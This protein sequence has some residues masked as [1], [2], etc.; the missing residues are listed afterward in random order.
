MWTRRDSSESFTARPASGLAGMGL[1]VAMSLPLLAMS[2][3]AAADPFLVHDNTA[4]R[5]NSTIR[6]CFG[7]LLEPE[8]RSC[9]YRHDGPRYGYYGP[10]GRYDATVDCDRAHPGYVEEVVR[11]IR[12]GG[13]LY[14]HAHERSCQ[15]SLTLSRSI[16]IVGQ[17]YGPDQIPAIVAPDGQP[18][19]TVAPT[20]THVVLK[21]VYMSSPRGEQSSCVTAAD[22]EV[23]IQGS[24][25][26]YQGE[27]PAVLIAGGRL[28][29]I[30]ASHVIAKT[31]GAAIDVSKAQLLA[32]DSEIATT[33][34]GI[35]AT[36]TG[37]SQI[38]GVSIQQLSD[39]HG[40]DRGENG[41]GVDI[42]LD[43]VDTVVNMSD[44]TIAFFPDAVVLDGPGEGLLAHSLLFH[45]DHGVTTWLDKSRIVEN[46]I[47][48]DEIGINVRGGTVYAGRNDIANVHTAGLLASDSGRIRAVD[49]R[50][51]P[52][53]NQC[54]TLKWGTVDPAERT[55]KPWYRGSEF[56]VPG[57]SDDQPMFDRFWPATYYESLRKFSRPTLPPVAAA[58]PAPTPSTTTAPVVAPATSNDINGTPAPA[59]PAT[60]DSSGHKHKRNNT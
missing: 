39:W 11:H 16:T 14:L 5:V 60:G 54:D 21:N 45:T 40:F 55:C 58:A 56:D 59:A 30:E 57:D 25:I 44:L 4:A 7:M 1:A 6:P 15:V 42:K 24:E 23:T 34:S 29:L 50:I 13:V 52:M 36:L 47:I 33:V 26:R 3:P 17:G 48:A 19:I 43:S 2:Q 49:N 41:V 28:N 51:D 38:Q 53:M 20:A 35:K 31:R 18:C 46:T 32:E 27:K 10:S 8:M 22:S 37:D 9:G 12:D